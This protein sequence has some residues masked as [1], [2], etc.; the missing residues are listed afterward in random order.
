MR[1][2]TPRCTSGEG[3]GQ[4][5]S[6]YLC[7]SQS[8]RSRR[9]FGLLL[10]G[11]RCFRP[12]FKRSFL[13]SIFALSCPFLGQTLSFPVVWA[14]PEPVADK[15]AS[16]LGVRPCDPAADELASEPCS[17]APFVN[18]NGFSDMAAKLRGFFRNGQ[19]EE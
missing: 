11:L 5:H 9:C 4:E 18:T 6:F 10:A 12:V 13:V 17:L 19:R 3:C 8:P 15:P 2:P 14:S 1:A 16:M 7:V